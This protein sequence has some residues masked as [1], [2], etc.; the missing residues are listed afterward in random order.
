MDVTHGF[1]TQKSHRGPRQS[2][3]AT[4]ALQVG[5][6]GLHRSQHYLSRFHSSTSLS[7]AHSVALPAQFQN[8][9]HD[10]LGLS[11]QYPVPTSVLVMDP[12]AVTKHHDQKQHDQEGLYFSLKLIL[13]H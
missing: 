10:R 11:K 5:L 3:C 1:L 13:H 7:C 9:P 12:I 6:Y 4:E 8:S 2:L